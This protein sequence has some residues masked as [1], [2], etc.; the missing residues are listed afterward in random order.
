MSEVHY[1]TAARGDSQIRNLTLEI[2]FLFRRY[3]GAVASDILPIAR[4][5]WHSN[6]QPRLATL[7]KYVDI[8]S[9]YIPEADVRSAFKADAGRHMVRRKR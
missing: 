5:D 8:L 3:S 9:S 2:E 6:F 4:S 1:T 7:K